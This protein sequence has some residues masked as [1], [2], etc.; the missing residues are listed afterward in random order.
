VDA[1]AAFE[2]ESPPFVSGFDP[3]TLA[4]EISQCGLELIEDLSGSQSL[5]RYGRSADA[6]LSRPSSSHVALARVKQQSPL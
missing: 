6:S 4:A 1:R 2:A 5:A 3:D